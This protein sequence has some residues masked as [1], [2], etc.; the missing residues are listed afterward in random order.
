MAASENAAGLL[1]RGERV[2]LRPLVPEDATARYLKWMH[3]PEVVRYLEA[4]FA[5]HSIESLRAFISD[6]SAR[7][8]TLLLAII[9]VDDD[10]LH[11]GNIKV[12]P[13]DPHH[14]T[15][16][17]GLLIGERRWWG[18]GLGSEAIALATRLA[19]K[20]LA[21]RKLTASCYSD[22]R[23]SARAFLRAGWNPE[24]RRPAQFVGEDGVQDQLMFGI[25][26]EAAP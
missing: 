23:A 11:V 20:R 19:A 13:R 14:G 26:L 10:A 4:R 17:L 9:A 1:I 7:D 8:D 3:D 18:K 15:A 24:G 25:V 16:D 12:G 22:N 5:S 2:G 6:Q 21:A